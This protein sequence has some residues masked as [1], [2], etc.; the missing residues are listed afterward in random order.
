VINYEALARNV[1]L[2]KEIGNDDIGGANKTEVY[3]E[4]LTKA[5]LRLTARM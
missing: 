2:P 3:F 4:A 1:I 5:T